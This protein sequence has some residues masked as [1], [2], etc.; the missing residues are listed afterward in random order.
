MKNVFILALGTLISMHAFADQKSSLTCTG[1]NVILKTK[2]PYFGEDSKFTQ[3]LFV[4]QSTDSSALDES[5]GTAYF[6]NVHEEGAAGRTFY[7]G[8]NEVGGKFQIDIAHFSD[9]GDGTIIQE[10]AEGVITYNH[11]YLKGKNEKVNCIRE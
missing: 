5:T 11:G 10:A 9:I 2:S 7:S 8:K 6:L 3:T 4:L 1:E